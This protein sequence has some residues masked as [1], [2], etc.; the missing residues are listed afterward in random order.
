[1]FFDIQVQLVLKTNVK[2]WI[3]H[4]KRY[5]AIKGNNSNFDIKVMLHLC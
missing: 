4:K 3:K 2:S 5:K 1:M